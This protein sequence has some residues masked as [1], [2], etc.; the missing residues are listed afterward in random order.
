[1]LKKRIIAISIICFV[2]FSGLLYSQQ[3]YPYQPPTSNPSGSD[4]SFERND[5]PAPPPPNQQGVVQGVNCSVFNIHQCRR[6]SKYCEWSY[7]KKK[8]LGKTQQEGGKNPLFHN[9]PGK[10]DEDCDS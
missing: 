7:G 4:C 1:M 6:N 3:Y 8:C 9:Q 10:D 5:V 2:I